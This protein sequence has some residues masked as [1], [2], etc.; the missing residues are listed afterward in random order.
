ML[1][2][3]HEYLLLALH[4][5]DGTVLVDNALLSQACVGAALVGEMMFRDRL[6]A[7]GPN[8]FALRSGPF[9]EGL[10]GKAE[11]MVA[12]RKPATLRQCM[13]FLRGDW[14]NR[15][16]Q[17]WIADDLVRLGVLRREK[18]KFWFITYNTRHPT[19]DLSTELQIRARLRAHL[20]TVQDSDPPHRDDGLISL[21]RASK[22]LNQVWATSALETTLQAQI[23]ERTKRAPLGLEAKNEA[24]AQQAAIT[25][26]TI[27]AVT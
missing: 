23:R 5:D 16:L 1:T 14:G 20:A 13:G 21:L 8:K 4:D 25:A 2:L 24:D 6:I 7:T 27:A 9:S 3:A 26:A 11:E 10:L 18:D 22:L 15:N 19:A 12:N 17:I